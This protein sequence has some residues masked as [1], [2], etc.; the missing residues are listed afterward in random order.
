VPPAD[1]HPWDAL[2]VNPA[3]GDI[4]HLTNSNL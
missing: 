1:S 4:A 3:A 2:S